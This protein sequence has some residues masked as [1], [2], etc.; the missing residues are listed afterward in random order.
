MAA[1]ESKEVTCRWFEMFL[2]TGM[3]FNDTEHF[4][5]YFTENTLSFLYKAQ[6]NNAIQR[7]SRYLF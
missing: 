6:Y 7:N 4:C 5:Y 1:R 3:H 2:E